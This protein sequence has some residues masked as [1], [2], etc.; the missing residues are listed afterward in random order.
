MPVGDK[1]DGVRGRG[2]LD[3]DMVDVQKG[4]REA[5]TMTERPPSLLVSVLW[6]Q[7]LNKKISCLFQ[8]R[9]LLT[10]NPAGGREAVKGFSIIE[11]SNVA[12]IQV[13][14]TELF[15]AD[16]HDGRSCKR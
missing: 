13:S 10:K 16:G 12:R 4:L 6:L 1:D 15:A 11:S 9:R 5:K 3:D 14:S 7:A 8:M 2:G